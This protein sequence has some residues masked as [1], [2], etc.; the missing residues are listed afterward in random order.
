MATVGNLVLTEVG[1][2]IR[3]ADFD[4]PVGCPEGG[5]GP[6]QVGAG[7]YNSG[8][9]M[10]AIPQARDGLRLL[11]RVMG[12]AHYRVAARLPGEDSCHDG[13]R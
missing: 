5:T 10:T 8:G 4:V 6:H 2:N 7:N 13:Q 11:R 3:A 1:C 9:A 12:M